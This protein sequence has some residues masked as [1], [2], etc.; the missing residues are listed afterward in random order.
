MIPAR[1]EKYNVNEKTH[2]LQHVDIWERVT[3]QGQW[4][5]PNVHLYV[6]QVHKHLPEAMNNQGNKKGKKN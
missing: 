6:W 5:I 4:P 2:L 3:H 1:K